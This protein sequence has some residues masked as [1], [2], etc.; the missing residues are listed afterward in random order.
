MKVKHILS[1]IALIAV[2]KSSFA[3][4]ASDA[5]QF[6]GTQTG[7]TSRVKGIGNANVSIGGDLT[8]VG[9]N[10]AGLGF[11]TRS[12]MSLTPEFN[13]SKSNSTYLGQSTSQTK[14]SGNLNNAS[15]VFYN[16]LNTPRGTDKT[17]GWLSINF[18]L[19]YNRTSDFNEKTTYS[20]TNTTTSI[21]DYYAD[22]ANNLGVDGEFVQGFAVDQKLISLYND[23][24]NPSAPPQFLANNPRPISVNQTN[25]LVRSGGQSEFDFSLGANY[26]NKLYIGLGIGITSLNYDLSRSFTENGVLSVLGTGTPPVSTNRNYT[27][28]YYSNQATKGAGFNAK[29][30]LIYK[31]VESV[32]IGAQFT[33]PTWMSIDDV[34]N[35]GLNA[36][37]A[38]VLK[39]PGSASPDYPLS[40]NMRTPYKAAG[41]LSVFLGKRGFITGD[42]EY[43]D[44]SSTKLT[45]N[46]AF[47][48]SYDNSIIKNT[49]KGVVNIRG[50]AEIKVVP[51]F[52]LRGGYGVLGS[53]LKA[54]GKATTMATGGLGYRFRDYYIDA[55]YQR[56][57]GTQ[58]VNPYLLG[59][60]TPTANVNRINNN[61]FLTVGLRF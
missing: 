14:N 52:M 1:L 23:P 39:T 34:Y 49:Y 26:S 53:P 21:N 35:E 58:I 18:G 15:V 30:G 32:R 36:Q 17:K 59:A 43:V 7:T 9:G 42:V 61:L 45:S 41:S 19:G 33:T 54:D 5:V 10:P 13:A 44:Y 25:N 28:T 27:S 11:F 31:I 16:R 57:S 47:D 3:Q 22:L 56:V 12:E 46:E 24:N 60:A 38:S 6:S 50:G 40:Y 37:I 29:L 55:A 51:N 20:G 48:A 2:G 4:Y 8:S